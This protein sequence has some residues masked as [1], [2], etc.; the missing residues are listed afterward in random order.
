LP[1]F[2]IAIGAV[3]AGRMQISLFPFDLAWRI[4]IS[5]RQ[6]DAPKRDITSLG[7]VQIA[8]K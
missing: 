2:S 4:A 6:F 5:P 3:A 7:V 1:Q 8:L